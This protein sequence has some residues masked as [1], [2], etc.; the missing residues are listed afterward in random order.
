MGKV[1]SQDKIEGLKV[2]TEAIKKVKESIEADK[3]TFRIK[4]EPKVFGDVAFDYQEL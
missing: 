3:G 1:N 2:L 4:T